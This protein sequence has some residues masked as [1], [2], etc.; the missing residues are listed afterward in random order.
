VKRVGASMALVTVLA[1]SACSACSAG[2]QL[3]RASS[4]PVAT[5]SPSSAS[6]DSYGALTT[7]LVPPRPQ[8]RPVGGWLSGSEPEWARRT[9]ALLSTST[10]TE[11]IAKAFAAAADHAYTATTAA[12]YGSSSCLLGRY[13]SISRRDGA[14]GYLEVLQ[15]ETRIDGGS[16]P[17]T[18]NVRRQLPDGSQLIAGDFAGDGSLFSAVDVRPDGLLVFVLIASAHSPSTSGWPTTIAAP[19]TAP[20]TKAPLSLDQTIVLTT[21]ALA[22][23]SA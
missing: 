4:R 16:F 18:I 23:V 5:A 15:L 7:C 22:I 14:E 17:I 2:G 13:I 8:A 21:R 9:G 10:R 6:V 12:D 11:A 20:D 1:S 3:I 19:S